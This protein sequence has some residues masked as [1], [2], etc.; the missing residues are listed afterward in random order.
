M[1]DT[2]PTKTER[3]KDGCKFEKLIWSGSSA[4]YFPKTLLK[5]NIVQYIF[6]RVLLTN[7]ID[8]YDIA[9]GY[10]CIEYSIPIH[11]MKNCYMEHIG[12]VGINGIQ[13]G[14]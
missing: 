2:F 9:M 6:N 7:T 11:L 14:V 1:A 12:V 5:T 3:I 4:V 13:Q 8:M 10:Y